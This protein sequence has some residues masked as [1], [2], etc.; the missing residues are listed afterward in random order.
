MQFGELAEADEE[1]VRPWIREFVLDH[2]TYW[3]TTVGRVTGK[4]ALCAH[5]EENGLVERDWAELRAAAGDPERY[6]RVARIEG[7]ICGLIYAQSRPEWYLCE[8]IGALSWIY[9]LPAWRGQG[10]GRKLIQQADAWMRE[11]GLTFAEVFVNSNNAHALGLYRTSGYRET[12]TR[13]TKGK[14]H[15]YD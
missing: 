5:I 12:D 10:I 7:A 3:H 8:R 9:V 15:I 14:D 4:A 2:L 11:R 13:M 1:H 6:V